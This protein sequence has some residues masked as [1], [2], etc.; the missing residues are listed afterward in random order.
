MHKTNVLLLT[1]YN[2]KIILNLLNV[3]GYHIRLTQPRIFLPTVIKLSNLV[4][5]YVKGK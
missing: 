3:V 1:V 5:E 2:F 4:T